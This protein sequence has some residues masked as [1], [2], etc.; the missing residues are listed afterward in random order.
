MSNI[1]DFPTSVPG[2][3]TKEQPRSYISVGRSGRVWVVALETP[4]SGKPLVT[5]LARFSSRDE[6]VEH[7]HA[8]AASMKGIPFKT[9]GAT[10]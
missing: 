9:K 6:A 5:V 10:R 3:D 2:T 4:C 7:G 1:I 8:T